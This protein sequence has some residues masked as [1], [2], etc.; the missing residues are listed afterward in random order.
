MI[1]WTTH[2]V[3]G[4]RFR[5]FCHEENEPLVRKVLKKAKAKNLCFHMT[6]KWNYRI[7]K[8]HVR[9]MIIDRN[10]PMKIIR[11]NSRGMVIAIDE[12][13]RSRWAS[14]PNEDKIFQMLLK[15]VENYK[16]PISL[17]QLLRERGEE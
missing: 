9:Y 15:A 13:I 11:K 4:Y 16:T 1:I 5:V 7:W 2:P 17:S 10:V 12:E 8:S 14:S 3:K 6:R